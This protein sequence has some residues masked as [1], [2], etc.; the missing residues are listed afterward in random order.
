M[1]TFCSTQQIAESNRASSIFLRLSDEMT[2]I[3][4]RNIAYVCG[5]SRCLAYL[6]KVMII[7]G[8]LECYLHTFIH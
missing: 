6:L 2:T 7:E 5:M 4:I 8:K 3:I 1:R